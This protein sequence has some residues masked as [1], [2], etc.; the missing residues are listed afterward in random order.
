MKNTLLL[1]IAIFFISCGKEDEV[2][3]PLPKAKFSTDVEFAT[4]GEP[5]HF[6][7]NSTDAVRFEWDL[8]D[9]AYSFSE[10]PSHTYKEYGIY[11]VTMKAFNTLEQVSEITIE[12]KIG[13]RILQHLWLLSSKVPLPSNMV[14]YFG[15][16]GN[17][18]YSCGE[19]FP[20]NVTQSHLPFG[21]T[22]I[23]CKDLVFTDKDWF[24]MLIDNQPPLQ[25]LDENDRLIFGTIINPVRV[26]RENQKFGTGEFTIYETK[27]IHG[28]ITTDYSMRVGY[29]IQTFL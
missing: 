26:A 10:N 25:D 2:I 27:N 20:A 12:I 15:E 19:V 18:N 21:G 3:V 4:I 9:G 14:F 23:N 1:L 8:G 6:T 16:V 28:E 22:I 17:P 5:I 24:W 13:K 29:A 11:T 7:N